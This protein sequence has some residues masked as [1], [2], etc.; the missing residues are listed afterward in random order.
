MTRHYFYNV[1]FSQKIVDYKTRN[2]EVYD[3]YAR[4]F[5]LRTAELFRHDVH[6]ADTFIALLNG[7]EVLDLGSGPGR[8]AQYLQQHGLQ[9]LCFD[10][11]LDMLE[12]CED[13]GLLTMR[14]DLE[15]LPFAPATFD[16]VWAHTSLLHMPKK[17]LPPVLGKIR[18]IL[19]DD[20]IFHCSMKEGD[21]EGWKKSEKY[22]DS[23]R[24]FSLYSDDELRSVLTPH[25]DIVRS[26]RESFGYAIFLNY[27]CRPRNF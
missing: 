23:E 3:R 24:F 2:R 15:N 6:N 4:E 19:R 27:L 10:F 11:S 18:Q 1:Y 21:F 5:E 17:N 22:G 20:G 9:P 7:A 25:F 16:G 26:A 12:L 8:Y 13:K 14:G